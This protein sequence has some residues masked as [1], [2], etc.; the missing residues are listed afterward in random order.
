MTRINLSKF[1]PFKEFRSGQEQAIK[2]LLNHFDNHEKIIELSAPTAS[3]KTLDLYIFGKILSQEY[4]QEKIMF[5]SPQVALITEG[6]LFGLPKLVGRSN[7]KCNAIQGYT[8]EDCP[9]SACESG[10]LAC[11]DCKYRLAKQAFR[12]A[13][14]GAVTFARYLADPTIY[15]KTKI[16]LIDESSELEGQLLDQSTVL[17]DLDAK[18]IT[19]KARV[20]DQLP[21]MKEF[22]TDFDVKTFLEK[23]KTTYDTEFEKRN[24]DLTDY[25]K[26]IFDGAKRKPT[27]Y[28]FK[29]LKTIQLECNRLKNKLTT[30]NNAIRY[31]SVDVPRVLTAEIQNS[32]NPISRRKE[33]QVESYF[34]LL[35]AY[36]PFGDLIAKLDCV[37]LASGT[38]TTQLVT[39]KYKTVNVKHP[40]NKERRL[41]YYD[42]V[43]SMN[44]QN[45]DRLASLMASRI[46]QLHDTFCK[47]TLVHCGSYYVAKLIYEFLKADYVICQEPDW[48][49]ESLRDWQKS[50]EGIFLSVRYEE[51]ISLDGPEYPINIIAKV[52]FPNLGDDWVNSRNKLDGWSWYNT[53]TACLI[54]QACGRTTRGPDDFSQTF[55]L[56]GSFGS[57][58]NRNKSLFKDWFQEAL[59]IS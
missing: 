49:E 1:S 4:N 48:R 23:Q 3:G 53:T 13:K 16:L 54:Q 12:D 50:S 34:K 19:K 29:K 21:L 8:A 55:I 32:W 59:V 36:M 38:P 39:T 25:K 27:Q 46:Q 11:N 20:S 9:F 28:E 30:C 33:P 26:S 43:G 15:Q 5:T 44:Y 7:Y 31:I 58:Y 18:S 40:I 47:K 41:I 51:G 52:P 57:F 10:F 56:D 2:E 42:P 24:K 45:R 22:L 6:N 35:N 17:L 37:V 14:F